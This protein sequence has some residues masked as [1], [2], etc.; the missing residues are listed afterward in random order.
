MEEGKGIL[1]VTWGNNFVANKYVA[2]YMFVCIGLHLHV[3]A[4][5]F[6]TK[7]LSFIFCCFL[8]RK[9]L[10]WAAGCHSKSSNKYVF[11]YVILIFSGKRGFISVRQGDLQATGLGSYV[12]LNSIVLGEPLHSKDFCKFNHQFSLVRGVTIRQIWL[13]RNDLVFNN[14]RWS[15]E[16]LHHLHLARFFRLYSHWVA[17]H[18][19]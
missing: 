15:T 9:K 4:L 11:K 18:F 5:Q 16:K 6:L 2:Q 10:M 8:K 12:I 13:A 7:D 3:V 1:L 19:H 14:Q 17:G